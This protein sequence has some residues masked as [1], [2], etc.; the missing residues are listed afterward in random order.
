[1]IGFTSRHPFAGTFAALLIRD[2]ENNVYAQIGLVTLIGLSAKN[3]ILIVEFTK[4]EYEN[5][6][7]LIEGGVD[8][9]R[10]RF[11][12]I[13]MTSFALGLA[14]C[15]CGRRPAPARLGGA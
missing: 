2:M 3:A 13:P 7:P 15:R 12:L 9:E 4:A 10:L 8:R 1:L 5:G 11:R 14:A 6:K